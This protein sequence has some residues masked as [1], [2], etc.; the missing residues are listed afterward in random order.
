MVRN[1]PPCIRP[2]P[3]VLMGPYAKN[4]NPYCTSPDIDLS[5]KTNPSFLASAVTE[6]SSG[7]TGCQ[8][9]RKRE[10]TRERKGISEKWEKRI[11]F[12]M[13]VIYAESLNQI[14][15]IVFEKSRAQKS[16]RKIIVAKQNQY[17][18]TRPEVG[19]P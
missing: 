11:K 6:L 12:I 7:Q 17:K 9:L 4:W 14:A 19:W 5:D 15:P 10:I 2:I 18:V 3:S 13:H 16:F 8:N 1:Y